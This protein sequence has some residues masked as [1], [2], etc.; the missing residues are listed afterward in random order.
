M[1]TVFIWFLNVALACCAIAYGLRLAGKGLDFV[2]RH[3]FTLTLAAFLV[4]VCMVYAETKPEPP[5]GP[6][7]TPPTPGTNEV[8][9]IGVGV[10]PDGTM[11]PYGAPIRE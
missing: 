4:A 1:K 7:P 3:F 11:I 5:P 10:R 2:S 6:P 9:R 8:Y